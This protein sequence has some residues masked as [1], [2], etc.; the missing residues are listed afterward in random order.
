[1]PRDGLAGASVRRMEPSPWSVE[2]AV[3]EIL[4]VVALALVYAAV[5]VRHRPS[6]ARAVA[7]GA[8]VALVAAALLSPLS[9]ISLNYLLAAHLL[10]NVV[11][12]EWAPLLLVLGIP[13]A[14]A[15][16]LGRFAGWRIATHP[17]VALPVWAAVYYAWHLPVAYDAALR[18]HSL[19]HLEHLSYLVAG[20]LLWWPVVQDA[21]H[22]LASSRRAVYCF[23]AFMLASPVALFLTL[24][25]DPI[26]AFYEEA[27]RLWGLSPLA[28]QQIAGV[29][30][31]AS[32][33]IVFFA[34]FAFFVF[35]FFEEEA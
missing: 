29:I 2:P 27:P 30:M 24:L 13:A 34:A 31:S 32:E 10:Q 35:R 3:G 7:Y 26:Y 15:A 33:A 8:G 18:N 28:D 23:A 9:T 11:L 19:L 4:I 21:P 25:P 5:V 22:E 14:A 17:L 16:E 6:R 20:S 12:A 1:M